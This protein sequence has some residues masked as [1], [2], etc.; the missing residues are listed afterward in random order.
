[1]EFKKFILSVLLCES[2]GFVGGFFTASSVGT[3]YSKL[4]KPALS[5]PNWVFGPVWTL[6]YFLMGVSLYILVTHDISDKKTKTALFFFALQLIL[7]IG[8]S[9]FFF[10][11]RNPIYAFFEIILLWTV[12][13]LTIIT[14]YK[15]DRVAGLILIPYLVW[16]GF[17]AYLNYG[18]MRLNP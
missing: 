16:T 18:I 5:P 17:A 9:F 2:V 4:R 13:A 14:A 3:W 15:V 11:L 10:G 12:I 6:L 8:W 1:M 7:N